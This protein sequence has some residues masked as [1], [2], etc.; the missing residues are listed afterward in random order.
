M[1][2]NIRT[3]FA[4]SRLYDLFGNDNNI[5]VSQIWILEIER[6]SSREL[7]FLYGRSLPDTYLSDCWR[8]KVSKVVTIY[9]NSSVK[10]HSLIMH[11]STKKLKAFLEQFISGASLQNASQFAQL[12]IS[13]DLA[14]AN[15]FDEIT[16][17]ENPITRPVMHLPTRDYYQSQTKQLSPTNYCSVDSGSVSASK[18]PEIFNVPENCDMVIAKAACRILDADTGMEFSEIDSWRLGDFEF[19]CAPGL[20]VNTRRKYDITLK[21]EQSSLKL[22]ESLTQEPSDLLVII[23]AYSDGSVQSS[24]I[25][26]ISKDASYPVCHSFEIQAFQ[27]Q[28]GTAYTMEIYALGSNENDSFLLI[29]T[30]NYFIREANFN[31]QL[32][33]GVRSNENFSWLDKKVPKKEKFRLEQAK[34]I[35][36]AARTSRSQIGGH[37]A[38]PWVATNRLI[39][40]RVKQ[41]CPDNSEGRFFP[42]LNNS[43]MSRIELGDWL[44]NIFENH[45]NA[46]IAW[47]DP[48]MEDVGIELLNRLGT[49]SAN[50]LIITTEKTS[51]SDSTNDSSQPTRVDNLLARCSGW[52]N[53]YFGSVDLKVLAVPENKLH[54]RMIL[55]RS[56]SG[57]P[58]AGY[59]LSNSIQRASENHPLLATPIPLDILPNV[60]DYIDKII[61]NTLYEPESRPLAKVIFDSSN[62]RTQMEENP[63]ESKHSY[64][65]SE[66]PYAGSVI[67][68]WLNDEQLSNLSGEALLGEM[69]KKGYVKDAQLD[70]DLFDALPAKFWTEGLPM[71]DF[72]SAWDALSCVIAKSPASRYAGMLYNK[73]DAILSEPVKFALL[74]H[75]ST[76]RVGALQPRLKK[77][78]IDI[79]YYRSQTLIDLLLS[80]DN[81][82]RIFEYL[83]VNT[84]WSDYYSIKILWLEDPKQLVS[85]LDNILANPVTRIR[86]R[87]LVVEALKHICLC[88]SFNKKHE[89]IDALLQSNANLINW[90]GL[91]AL[92][93]AINRDNWGVE[94]LSKINH[95]EASVQRTIQCWMINE[96]NYLNSDIKPEL[97]TYLVDSL[98]SPL[99]DRELKGILDPVRG[100][101]GKLHHFTPWILESILRP[102][103][104][105]KKVTIEQ[106]ANQWLK[107]I[108]DQWRA[109]LKDDDIHFSLE[110]DGAFTDELAVLTK[111]VNS[112]TQKNIFQELETVFEKLARTI[113]RPMSD[114]IN[115]KSYSTAHQVNLW[116]YGLTSKIAVMLPDQSEQFDKLLADSKAIMERLS[117]SAWDSFSINGL[118]NYGTSEPQIICSH[119][120]HQTIQTAVNVK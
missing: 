117:V 24:Y 21:G 10:I 52:N 15:I 94:A 83:P 41:L 96:A 76:S 87:T 74:Q 98:H 56:A 51:N 110:T 80:K 37:T 11:T 68:W 57:Q 112:D 100:R 29:Q 46:K 20:N 2:N 13:K 61:Q 120:L 32:L 35:G 31:L 106:V 5:T 85:W 118:S 86:D 22:F 17:G 69:D 75:L 92:A 49:D 97:I 107:E 113:R 3:L 42:T 116:L 44:K 108:V 43:N 99:T 65:F 26:T 91:H 1:L 25:T 104:E 81:P 38:D 84:S 27:N 28:A 7:R 6:E 73:E 60:F 39:Q 95:I 54:D 4:D 90:I 72:S 119:H 62:S 23:K 105:Q 109:A 34:Q 30:G 8:G 114:Q 111:Y 48:Y 50:Y 59:H 45:H 82:F 12:T 115:W 47:V 19:I 55:I 79:E 89:Q 18:K 16:F 66:Y 103:I 40:K 88:I 78:Q 9:D 102:M 63:H 93:N 58:L 77:I 33:D 64:S 36:R 70:T 71:T 67:A 14:E 101:L 53:G